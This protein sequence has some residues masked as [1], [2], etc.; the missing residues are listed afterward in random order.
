MYVKEDMI[1]PLD[2]SFHDLLKSKVSGSKGLLFNLERVEDYWR[3]TGYTAKILE[4]KWYE[5]N[6]HIFPASK[7][8]LFEPE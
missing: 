2:Y 4:R 8:R 6:K 5:K 1:I 3:D 7:W